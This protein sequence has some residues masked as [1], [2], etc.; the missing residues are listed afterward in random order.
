[1]IKETGA[2]FSYLR[3]RKRSSQGFK[4]R[5]RSRQHAHADHGPGASRHGSDDCQ[6]LG[7]LFGELNKCLRSLGFSQVVF[8]EKT[9]DPVVIIFF[10][11]M[12][13][14][15]GLQAL[16]LVGVLCLVIIFI[17]K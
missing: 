1:M 3:E 12:L 6:R 5:H 17:Q 10:W 13:G 16:G 9:V 11:L 4:R 2:K 14:F 15:L 8:G 7:T